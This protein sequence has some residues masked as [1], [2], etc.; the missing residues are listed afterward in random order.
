[1][2]ALASI[3]TFAAL[4][5]AL[6]IVPGPSV[7]FILSRAVALG[8]KA[9][10]L[11]ILGNSTGA[12]VQVLLV[13]L[14]VGVLVERSIVLFTVIKLA[15]AAYLVWLGLTTMFRRSSFDR[16]VD[17]EEKKPSKVIVREGLVVGFTNPKS[18]VFFA[19]FLPQFVDSGGLPVQVQMAGLG[20]VF[21]A[22]AV[23]CDGFYGFV[24]GTARDWFARSSA[25]ELWMNRGAGFVMV[26]L[27]ARLLTT[28]GGS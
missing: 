13:S 28:R 4:S 24:A 17:V 25:R 1:M 14:G 21:T 22:V 18:F 2:P 15:G 6:I 10:F 7:L 12:Y 26:G 20:L 16:Q 8:R 5:F 23:V 3:A 19:A 27:G 9:A 11:T